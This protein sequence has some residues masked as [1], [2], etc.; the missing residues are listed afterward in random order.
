[1]KRLR[2]F[3][4]LPFIFLLSAC[5]FSLAEDI[6]P[7]A[8]SEMLPPV[9]TQPE[10]VS[11]PV[12]P[13]VA[14]DPN[15]GA[16]IFAEKCAPCHGSSGMGDGPQS[17]GLSVPV[18]PIGDPQLA[19]Q[20]TPSDW[21]NI[22]TKGNLER[23]MPPF[24]SLNDR[25]RWDVV[26]YAFSLS[27]NASLINEGEALYQANCASCHG[28]QGKGDGPMA[29][30]LSA[31]L[32]DFSDQEFMA[33]KSA[34]NLTDAVRQGVGEAMPAFADQFTD[35]QYWALAAFVRSLGYAQAG[36]GEPTQP[37][38]DASIPTQEA[39]SSE[40]D[41]AQPAQEAQSENTVGNVKVSVLDDT[42]SLLGTEIPVT[43]YA[44]DSMEFVY[45]TTLTTNQEGFAI[46]DN[47]DMPSGRAF[48][49]SVDFQDVV[50]GS[51]IGT[52]VNP[53]E[54]VDL[55][56]TVYETTTDISQLVVDRLH[57]F[58]DF[59]VPDTVQ[60][61]EL[62]IMRNLTNQTIVGPEKDGPVV[63]FHLPDS[64]ANLQFQDGEIGGR[65]QQTEDG[66]ADTMPI[67][68]GDEYQVVFA[69]DMPYNRRLEF[70][71]TQDLAVSS[72][73]ILA[74]DGIKMR[75]DNLTDSG[76]RDVQGTNYR[77]YSINT[78]PANS[79]ITLEV[80]GSPKSTSASSLPDTHTSLI[81]GLGALGIA[82]VIAGVWLYRRD[83]SSR[84]EED[85]EDEFEDESEDVET[86]EQIM[87]AIIALDDLYKAG[88]LPET[89]YQERRSL[90]KKK[91]EDALSVD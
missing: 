70:S 9:E 23:F 36:G 14:P 74:P 56:I 18:A 82:L 42:G 60:V 52:P 77:M 84:S 20:R 3:I 54:P 59:S 89:A 26:A 15:L 49:S 34:T 8:G 13:I 78:L 29:S 28:A 38:Q 87:D 33:V 43:L 75:G 30:G 80:S 48:L 47:V 83:R 79:E 64:A 27:E 50:Y 44:F 12:F 37:D 19:R 45:S 17:A 65:Y 4:I 1:M 51:D 41:S 11:A 62:Y 6:K 40:G 69:Y 76:L 61:V 58:F 53:D 88:E 21:F 32:A 66:F 86:P 63:H 24:S 90:L 67:H 25:Q 5:T 72:A 85:I 55:S 73:I 16:P 10:A 7:P 68:P 91:L 39:T 35:D 81:I 71:Q 57:I 22:V 46:F 2:H 31:P